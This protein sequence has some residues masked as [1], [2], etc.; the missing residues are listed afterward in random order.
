VLRPRV[1]SPCKAINVVTSPFNPNTFLDF[2]GAHVNYVVDAALASQISDF[3]QALTEAETAVGSVN[4]GFT[5]LSAIHG[6]I[7][8]YG[9]KIDAVSPLRQTTHY[10]PPGHFSADDGKQMTFTAQVTMQDDLGKNVVLCLGSAG[11]TVPAKGPIPGV[12]VSWQTDGPDLSDYGTLGYAP[13]ENG[14][15][16]LGDQTTGADGQVTATYTPKNEIVPGVGTVETATGGVEARALWGTAFENLLGTINQVVTPKLSPELFWTVTYHKARGYKFAV[17]EAWDGVPNPNGGSSGPPSGDG[18]DCG[19]GADACHGA[20]VKLHEDWTYTG[21]TC[22]E[23]PYNHSSTPL[24]LGTHWKIGYRVEFQYTYQDGYVRTETET[25]GETWAL[26]PNGQFTG[27]SLSDGRK[28]A[29]F[30]LRSNGTTP[31]VSLFDTQQDD[32]WAW[33]PSSQTKSS[34]VM[35]DA[36]CPAT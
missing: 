32:Y 13:A 19:S 31:S 2:G 5:V 29:Q 17:S 34:A 28:T 3:V 10:G 35:E 25:G 18:G 14:A 20:L 15:L 12:G 11:F 9:I 16:T 21:S 8:A 33:T 4:L 26:L 22:G 23:D 30:S 27:G 7:L 24:Y 6:I 1:G 36:T